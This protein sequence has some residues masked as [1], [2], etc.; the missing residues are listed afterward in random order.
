MTHPTSAGIG[1]IRL[2]NSDFAPAN[3]EDDLRGKGVLDT[4]GQRMGTVEDL[5]IDRREREVRFLEVGAGGILGIG[6]KRFLVPVEAVTKVAE[7]WVT[8]EPGRTESQAGPA[9]FE[10]KVRPP[11]AA[12]DRRAD[13][14]ASLPLAHRLY[15]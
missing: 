15:Q 6:E 7:G 12:E 8:I 9:P 11:S 3:L 4:E 13:E 14:P 5:Y 2:G 10:T 1:L